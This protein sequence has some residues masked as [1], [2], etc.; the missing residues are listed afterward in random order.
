MNL[1]RTTAPSTPRLCSRCEEV[2]RIEA[3][4]G[5]I[6]LQPLNTIR[7]A[8]ENATL[9]HPIVTDDPEIVALADG[10]RKHGVKEP[11]VVTTDGFILSGHRL[12]RREAVAEWLRRKE[13]T[14]TPRRGA[15]EVRRS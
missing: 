14:G 11:L 12:F 8:P 7:P 9:Y 2:R 15:C 10:V 6:R 5:Q 1:P 3:K 4:A 13:T